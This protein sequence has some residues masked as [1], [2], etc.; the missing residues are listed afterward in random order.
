MLHFSKNF[1]FQGRGFYRGIVIYLP[2]PSKQ[3]MSNNSHSLGYD[4]DMTYRV[5][6]SFDKSGSLLQ[7]P[8]QKGS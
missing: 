2:L 4:G 8:C 5:F 3:H 6:V 7:G 1:F